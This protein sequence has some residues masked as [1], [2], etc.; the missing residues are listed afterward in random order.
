MICT[1]AQRYSIAHYAKSPD[2]TS[3]GFYKITDTISVD[4][5]ILLGNDFDGLLSYQASE[6]GSNVWKVCGGGTSTGGDFS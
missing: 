3:P 1:E 2:D 4:G 5:N 6:E